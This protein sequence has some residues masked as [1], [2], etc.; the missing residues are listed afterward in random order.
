M[1]NSANFT[2]KRGHQMP[3]EDKAEMKG[4]IIEELQSEILS[5][6]RR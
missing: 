4:T 6:P 5:Q 3:H 1:N 2:L